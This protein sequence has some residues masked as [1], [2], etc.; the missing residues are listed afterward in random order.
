VWE[1]GEERGQILMAIHPDGT[2]KGGWSAD[3]DAIS[4]RIHYL[5]MKGDFKGNTDPSKMYGDKEGEDPSKLY[6]ITKGKFLILETNFETNKVRK[7]VGNIYVVGWL[8]PDLSAFG[9][10][11]VT[12]DQKTQK[13]YEWKAVPEKRMPFNWLQLK[14]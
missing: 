11:H 13:I 6:F 10:V 1:Q 12:P 5:V 8:S 2:V 3:Y 7:I 4:P 9:R 14:R